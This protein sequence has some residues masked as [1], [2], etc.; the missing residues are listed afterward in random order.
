M[1]DDQSID[2]VALVEIVPPGDALALAAAMQRALD[3]P[4]PAWEGRRQLAAHSSAWTWE[5]VSRAVLAELAS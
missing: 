2:R 5:H 3:R 4:P 1:R